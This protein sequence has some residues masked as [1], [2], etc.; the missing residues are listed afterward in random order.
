MSITPTRTL[1]RGRE[2]DAKFVLW[3]QQPQGW[4]CSGAH[5]GTEGG[6]RH[7]TWVE[8]LVRHPLHAEDIAL[9]G[10]YL[11]HCV[12]WAP[13]VQSVSCGGDDL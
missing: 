4:A 6:A 1:H 8:E 9:V 2:D 11:V 7:T 3:W 12:K 13:S 10:R 5:R